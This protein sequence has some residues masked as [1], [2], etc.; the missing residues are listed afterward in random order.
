MNQSVTSRKNSD[1]VVIITGGARGIGHAF[2]HRLAEDGF[3][4]AIVDLHGAE[5]GAQALVRAGFSAT[6]FKANVTNASN[7]DALLTDIA[8]SGKA[9]HGLVNNAAMFA[10]LDMQCFEQVSREEWMQVMEVNTY[11]PFLATQK[12]APIL[13][14]NGGGSIVNIASTSPLKGVTGMPHYVC[15]KGAVIA[16]TR[17]LARELGDR[18]INVNAVAP[19]F[20]LSDGILLNTEHV[21]KFRDIGKNSR[22][23]KRDQLPRDLQGAVSFLMSLDSQFMTGQTLVVDGGAFFV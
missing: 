1:H 7:W 21:E 2:A 18:G 20:T 6:G 11:G 8:S 19:G 16:L 10:S 13:A 5:E 9:L 14:A 17:T 3:H 23:M 22:A 4:V 12:V 15:S